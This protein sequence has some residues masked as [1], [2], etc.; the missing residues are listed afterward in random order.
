MHRTFMYKN[1][2]NYLNIDPSDLLQTMSFSA[3]VF[4]NQTPHLAS[5]ESVCI[6]HCF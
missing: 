3:Q 2:Q 4:G 5:K 6:E 1:L